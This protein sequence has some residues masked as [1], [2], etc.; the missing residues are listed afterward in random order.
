MVKSPGSPIAPRL[1]RAPSDAPSTFNL[2]PLKKFSEGPDDVSNVLEALARTMRLAPTAVGMGPSDKPNKQND[3]GGVMRG[4]LGIAVTTVVALLLGMFVADRR[5]R[6]F[7]VRTFAITVAGGSL[8][9]ALIAVTPAGSRT[10]VLRSANPFQAEG[11]VM[12]LSKHGGGL[13]Q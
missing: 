13:F 8:L 11:V 1:A 5:T 4:K 2:R 9:V 12:S 10:N 3:G 6:L 7:G